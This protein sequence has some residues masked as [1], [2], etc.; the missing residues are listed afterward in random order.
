[1]EGR[2]EKETYR[3]AGKTNEDVGALDTEAQKT[4]EEAD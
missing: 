3:R 1:M 4:E 2:V